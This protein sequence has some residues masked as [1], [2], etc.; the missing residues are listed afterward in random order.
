MGSRDER[1]VE[2]TFENEQFERGVAQSRQSLKDLEKSLQ[3]EE[4]AKGFANI[5]KAADNVD[6]S[7]IARGVEALQDRF[8]LFGIMGMKV[9][10]EIAGAAINFGKNLWNMTFGQIKSGG[11][12]RAMNVENAH[13]MLQGLLKD[14]E[15]VKQIM[16]WA[17]DSVDGTAYSYDEAAKAASQ[18]AASNVI[19]EEDM[20]RALRGIT[21]VAAMTNSQYE[22]I[23]RIFTTVAGNGR[24]MGE[25]LLQFSG[26]GLNAAATIKDF[27][28]GINAGTK[29]AGEDVTKYVKSLTRGMQV[30]EEQIRD[31]VSKGKIN[32]D[33]FSAAMDEAFG[34]HAK[35]ANETLTGVLSN[36]K[37][38]LSK[39]GADFV[40]PLV[41]Q[42]GP[43]VEFFN[44]LRLAINKVRA[45]LGPFSTTFVET[46]KK[47][48]K[49]GTTFLNFIHPEY[50]VQAMAHGL[51]LLKQILR[52]IGQAFRE[53]FGETS[54][55][56][57]GVAV[58]NF[59]QFIE[60]LTISE[61]AVKIIH[62]VF[63][64]FFATLSIGKQIFEA[65]LQLVSPLV[66]ILFGFGTEVA[67]ATGSVGEHI[68]ALDKW[69][70]ETGFLTEA[71]EKIHGAIGKVVDFIK[72][73]FQSKFVQDK[74]EL[75]KKIVGGIVDFLKSKFG[76]FENVKNQ[77][78]GFFTEVKNS[79]S[80]F[81][82]SDTFQSIKNVIS[83]FLDKM[84][85]LKDAIVKIGKK[86]KDV[87]TEIFS[88]FSGGESVKTVALDVITNAFHLLGEAISFVFDLISNFSG[89]LG[90]IFGGLGT[91]A[92]GV[93]GGLIEGI[94]GLFN[95][96]NEGEGFSLSNLFDL[97]VLGKIIGFVGKFGD[98]VKKFTDAIDAEKIK[99]IAYAIGILT[100]SLAGIAE[101]DQ[102]KLSGAVTTL[103]ILFGEL[104]GAFKLMKGSSDAMN[105]GSFMDKIKAIVNVVKS[106]EGISG[107][108][109][110]L[111]NH[112]DDF[113][114]LVD[115]AKSVLMASGA[116]IIL[117]FIPA[118]KLKSSIS[119]LTII[120]VELVAAFKILSKSNAAEA[121]KATGTIIAFAVAADLLSIAL[122]GLAKLDMD[123]IERGAIGL[124]YI[125]LELSL[126]MKSLSKSGGFEM[127]GGLSFIMLATSMII[128]GK[129]LK[130]IS[131][132]SFDQIGAGLA[133]LAGGLLAM[134]EAMA[135]VATHT[136]KTSKILAVGTAITV[137]CAGMLILA[138]AVKRVSTIDESGLMA[139]LV[140]LPVM[141]AAITA[142]F[143]A[144]PKDAS[145]MSIGA[146]FTILSVG[147]IALAEAIKRIG[148]SGTE[149]AMTGMQAILAF[150]T[151]AALA[152]KL[153]S[154]VGGWDIIGIAAGFDILAGSLLVMATALK[155]MGTMK[156]DSLITSTM[157]F[158]LLLGTIAVIF[159]GMPDD[160]K[161]G[162]TALGFIGMAVALNLLSAA[163]M[164]F[165]GAVRLIASGDM[166]N[167][168]GA[169]SV[170]MIGLAGMTLALS[171]LAKQGPK[172]LA[173]GGAL[174]AVSG[175]I[176]ILAG[177]LS[178]LSALPVTTLIIASAALAAT[179]TVLVIALNA[180]APMADQ[181][182]KLGMAFATFGAGIAMG[183]IGIAA[184][185]IA[186]AALTAALAGVV[187][188]G[189][190]FVVG[191]VHIIKAV[192]E[193]IGELLGM[194]L[195]GLAKGFADVIAYLDQHGKEIGTAIV[196][197]LSSLAQMIIAVIPLTLVAIFGAVAES[198]K[199]LIDSGI[200]KDIA[201]SVLLIVGQSLDL[202]ITWTPEII[203][204]LLVLVYVI[205]DKLGEH[206]GEIIDHI[207]VFIIRLINAIAEGVVNHADPLLNAV[208]NIVKAILYFAISLLQAVL[209]LIPGIGDELADK[210]EGVK[211]KLKNSMTEE[212]G[213]ALLRDFTKG[214]EDQLDEA[215]QRLQKA[216][217]LPDILPEDWKAAQLRSVALFGTDSMAAYVMAMEDQEVYVQTKAM[218]IINSPLDLAEKQKQLYEL[219][220]GELIDYY[221]GGIGA[222]DQVV[223]DALDKV[224]LMEDLTAMEAA[225]KAGTYAETYAA[226]YGNG[227]D[228]MAPDMKASLYDLYVDLDEVGRQESIDSWRAQ[229]Q[230]GIANYFEALSDPI[231]FERAKFYSEALARAGKE[232]FDNMQPE[233]EDSGVGLGFSVVEGVVKTKESMNGAVDTVMDSAVNELGGYLGDFK[234]GG[235]QIV[236][237]TISGITGKS[238]DYTNVMEGL[239]ESGVY[240][241]DSSLD[242]FFTSGENQVN[243]VGKGAT[244]A[245]DNYL[246]IMSGI[247]SKG[248][249]E[250]V[251]QKNE[252]K[253]AGQANIGEY[254]SA[255]SSNQVVAAL[256][257]AIEKAIMA[258]VNKILDMNKRFLSGGEQNANQYASG[259]N[260]KKGA[261]EN[262]GEGLAKSGSEGAASKSGSFKQAGINSGS[263][264]ASGIENRRSLVKGSAAVIAQG[265][266]EG[267]GSRHDQF[268][269]KGHDAGQ[270][271]ANGMQEKSS[272]VYN[273]AWALAG[274]ALAGMQNRLNI[275]SPSKE[276]MK[277]GRSMGE[278]L[279][280][281]LESYTTR[282]KKVSS[283]FAE[284]SLDALQNGIAKI[285][286]IADSSM[287][288]APTITPVLD[289]SNVTSG[290]ASMNTMFDDSRAVAAQASFD[291]Y[292]NYSNPD[293]ISQFAKMSSDNEAKMAKI[294]DKQTDVLLDIRTRLAHQQIVLDSGEL[295]GA[296]IN[297][298][299][300]AL[301]ERMVR[302]GRGN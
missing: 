245:G 49:N 182:M 33:T 212:D 8:S 115:L 104:V 259:I 196:N 154:N 257:N 31:F 209:R 54:I 187:L 19:A 138:E 202:L 112:E 181:V 300:E 171:K 223:S 53:V 232:G 12:R 145:F 176:L 26:R 207:M 208:G 56:R 86:I 67:S 268:I 252:F 129:A 114:P 217:E 133:G 221:A 45:E 288:Y 3:L 271:F 256:T 280:V 296:T 119:A 87:F 64:G 89:T 177:A 93:L 63:G 255:L 210:F 106:K 88:R 170:L 205:V 43:L 168:A 105:S 185:A 65:L 281:G 79:V 85:T 222:K 253:G 55:Y 4:G 235:G 250:L 144:M 147:L 62:D 269:G 141:L 189:D 48:L 201:N 71:V 291:M 17:M 90:T 211:G 142:T 179:I 246:K 44:A 131:S 218:D 37:A 237:S 77:I 239:G 32:F 152:F 285:S 123:S 249:L 42:N 174:V 215:N 226:E 109:D 234:D 23:S 84:V 276:T 74:I 5:S 120:F 294:I 11:I 220:G 75:F 151:S 277:F 161:I 166:K 261:V 61:K 293:Y 258:V 241:I 260:S 292:Q 110:A 153:L 289:L 225:Y 302:A 69:L 100:L 162:S 46:A 125:L 9:I 98:A 286:K 14:E 38:A 118:D 173:A 73:I 148:G 198:L 111:R 102:E 229:G 283:D 128:F 195:V 242:G 224:F 164:T 295:V 219:L 126:F 6:L 21:G 186:I 216:Y 157:A 298:I 230:I 134:A 188:M 247:G 136:D 270:G 72:G 301:G 290:I 206:L 231:V 287:D 183:G 172:V 137:I 81:L 83:E 193:A 66:R 107:L 24:L 227:I 7:A 117:S 244:S 233:Y 214:L 204:K 273:K 1:I 34:E 82:R 78:V 180:L 27:F 95:S 199:G 25:Q 149:G 36:V 13:F 94:S 194:I 184:V 159:A 165:A 228:R 262:A 39:I 240:G 132:L 130:S 121:S 158:V 10:E 213:Q 116:L 50:I 80:N 279:E 16:D 76:S 275:N 254:A 156:M 108:L 122:A 155:L 278:G 35:K 243:E 150:I 272:T 59:K 160:A 30:S 47:I 92:G 297:K 146:S 238:V 175:M 236:D 58:Y 60:S 190:K 284:E 299:D 178:L 140:I 191:I 135:I 101:I 203:E 264:F 99:T 113:K 29:Q 40:S 267:A 22:D 52:P 265:G 169:T 124:A 248:P 18:F 97:V 28:N 282:I 20:R 197:L 266:V 41:T 163:L 103:T 143:N 274:Q 68:I 251:R 57:M 96:L 127:K 200:I 15:Q 70:K 2:M 51:D 192:G 139:A 263:N 91:V 167:I